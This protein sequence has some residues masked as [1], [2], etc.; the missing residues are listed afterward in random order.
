MTQQASV[1]CH[2]LTSLRRLRHKVDGVLSLVGTSGLPVSRQMSAS[3]SRI[4]FL[5]TLVNLDAG[6]DSAN[7]KSLITLAIPPA[8]FFQVKGFAALSGGRACP[9][10]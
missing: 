8:H 3:V 4:V 1:I 6:R 2:D 5:V 10:P 7:L 9:P